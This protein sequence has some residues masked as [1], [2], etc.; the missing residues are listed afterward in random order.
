M[1]SFDS[2]ILLVI[3]R[4]TLP[5]ERFIDDSL[6][7]VLLPFFSQQLGLLFLEDK[8]K[9]HAARV[10]MNCFTACANTSFASQIARSL[11][12]RAYLGYYGKVSAF[13]REC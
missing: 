7:A 9:M 13:T 5:T 2:R 1:N 6:R 12:N 4:G 3:I 8:A 11:F 10:A